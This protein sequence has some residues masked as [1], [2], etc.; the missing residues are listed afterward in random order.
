MGLDRA[1]WDRVQA[2]GEAKGH[3]GDAA[4]VRAGNVFVLPAEPPYP[5]EE[6]FPV[7][8]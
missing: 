6:V 3:Q 4:E 2:G 1:E 5:I 8:A 7:P